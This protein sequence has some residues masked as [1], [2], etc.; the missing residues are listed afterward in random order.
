MKSIRIIDHK[1]GEDR[2]RALWQA[3]GLC[4]IYPDK[5]QEGRGALFP[6]IKA[7]DLEK[8]LT[9]DSR[10]KVK[11]H[12]FEVVTPVEWE[13]MKSVVV[14]ELDRSIK[15]YTEAEI[16]Q[17]IDHH[18]GWAKVES[19]YLFTTN[20]NMMKIRFKNAT[21]ANKADL[22]GIIVA[23]QSI[24]AKKVEKEIFIRLDPCRNC[25]EYTHTTRE[26]PED[27]MVICVRCGETG[28]KLA[29]CNA[30]KPNCK[31]CGEEHHALAARCRVRKKIIKDKRKEVR[32]K[33]RSR[34]RSQ[35][36]GQQQPGQTYSGR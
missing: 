3:L 35:A 26:C 34:S 8:L 29:Q 1:K 30:E 21:M 31:N 36:R 32:D 5:I 20:S 4:K 22:E 6:I 11:Q 17:M 10:N 12:G 28:H 33:T 18:N 9:E 23:C 7:E 13:A 19:V 16:I 15:S 2:V 24:P 27:K 25:L 14:C